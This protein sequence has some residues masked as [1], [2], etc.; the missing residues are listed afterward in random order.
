MAQQ[1]RAPN[2]FLVELVPDGNGR[3]PAPLRV[4]STPDP[5]QAGAKAGYQG[6]C[7]KDVVMGK[8]YTHEWHLSAAPELRG[9]S[10]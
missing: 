8:V 9:F 1:I 3:E 6:R 7:G 2:A 4:G 5:E 10:A